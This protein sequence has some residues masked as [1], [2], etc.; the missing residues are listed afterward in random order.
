MEAWGFTYKAQA[1]WIKDR[2]GLGLVF[3][4]RHEVLL[5]GT[6]GNMPGPQYQPPSVFEYPRGRHS[7]KPPEVRKAIERMY[8]DFSAETRLELFARE[9]MKDWTC[10]GNE[11]TP[12]LNCLGQRDQAQRTLGG[13]Q[14][15]NEAMVNVDPWR[16]THAPP[17][18]TTTR[19]AALP[20]NRV[21]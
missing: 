19:W 9:N 21:I 12:Q 17:P 8:P 4:N 3:R 10:C 7:A 15:K 20:N 5:Y 11:V 6:R 2:T 1:V 16:R 13:G 14:T 18:S